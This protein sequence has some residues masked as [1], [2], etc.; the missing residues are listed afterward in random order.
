MVFDKRS[1]GQ[2]TDCIDALRGMRK[3]LD[4]GITSVAEKIV[5]ELGPDEG[6]SLGQ[7][8]SRSVAGLRNNV[9][10]I[11]RLIRKLVA[12][13][14][15]ERERRLK[16]I[17]LWNAAVQHGAVKLSPTL[18]HELEALGGLDAKADASCRD[19]ILALRSFADGADSF[20]MALGRMEITC[21]A[22][23]QDASHKQNP[24][25]LVKIKGAAQQKFEGLL[26][27]LDGALE[28]LGLR[29]EQ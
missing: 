29:A 21:H 15:H 24:S 6:D 11:A 9:Q 20:V 14:D 8:R 3:S 28:K 25:E 18:T 7:V 5:A 19:I 4:D 27:E 17:A 2:E 22:E 13:F 1:D 12:L 23:Q 16:G 26:G 10:S